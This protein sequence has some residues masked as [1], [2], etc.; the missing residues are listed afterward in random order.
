MIT[1]WRAAT[2]GVGQTLTQPN[3][4]YPCS[5]ERLSG[6][7]VCRFSANAMSMKWQFARECIHVQLQLVYHSG[8]ALEC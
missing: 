5:Q 8:P 7:L 3:R 1:V 6:A 4:S 2:N